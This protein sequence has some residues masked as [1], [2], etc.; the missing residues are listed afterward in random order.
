MR[1]GIQGSSQIRAKIIMALKSCC[2][3]FSLRT[4]TNIIGGLNIVGVIIFMI[5]FVS[6]LVDLQN[7]SEQEIKHSIVYPEISYLSSLF[8]LLIAMTIL[9]TIVLLIIFILLIRGA[10][11]E[12]KTLLLPW[13]GLQFSG[14]IFGTM[15]ILPLIW[16]LNNVK[17]DG[18]AMEFLISLIFSTIWDLYFFLVVYGYYQE[19]LKRDEN[20]APSVISTPP[21]FNPYDG[22]AKV[23]VSNIYNVV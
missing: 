14:L 4:G 2:C 20:S 22:K 13:L 15:L 23:P 7:Q 17:L 12:R 16:Y 21:N 8:R 6:N 10:T 18:T 5:V 11:K 19:L 3:C 9:I 1:L